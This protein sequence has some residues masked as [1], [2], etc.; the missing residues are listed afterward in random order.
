MSVR[1][2]FFGTHLTAGVSAGIIILIMC[3]TGVMLTYEKQ[4]VAWFD[5]G[6]DIAN[7][8]A[9]GPMQP[10][11]LLAS[12]TVQM[13]APPDSLTLRADPRQPAQIQMGRRQLYT[14]PYTG[15]VLGEG[16]STIRTFF[17][18]VTAWHRWLGNSQG[19][20]RDTA[21]VFTGAANLLFVVI[22][23]IGMYLWIPRKLA[24][25]NFRAVLMF[26]GG[27][28]GKARDFN[29]HNTIGIWCAV[30]LFFI[31]LSGVVM[32]YPWA[33]QLLFRLSGSPLPQQGG[34]GPGG[35]GGEGRGGEQTAPDYAGINAMV[36][37][38]ELQV[39]GWVA[40]SLRVPNGKGP[41]NVSVDRSSIPGNTI[42]FTF[43][44]RTG[45]LTHT[46]MPE[47]ASL[48]ARLRQL[49]RFGHTGE[50][51]GMFGQTIAGI[52]S[53]GGVFLAWTG[54]S[55][56]WRRFRSW[57]SRR[58]REEKAEPIAA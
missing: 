15:T 23:A 14:N 56:S 47:D 38:A 58:V 4:I 52:A 40:V 24:W 20:G 17:Q 41:V 30:P 31:A 19:A 36:Q 34:R 26:R 7:P 39:P 45:E 55:L 2:L 35:R 32:S 49:V 53:L 5:R 50:V 13:Q 28:S 22:I 12:A 48:G 46:E 21:R 6:F 44:R 33:N 9:T 18:Q 1:K 16:S 3:F 51:G 43:D 42:R 57:R 29:W 25:P 54:L 37:K 8:S 10:E 27:L 11:A